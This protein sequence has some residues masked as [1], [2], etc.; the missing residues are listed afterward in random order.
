LFTTPMRLRNK[1]NIAGNLLRDTKPPIAGGHQCQCTA[2]RIPNP[3]RV[4]PSVPPQLLCRAD[5]GRRSGRQAKSIPD[6]DALCHRGMIHQRDG[7]SPGSKVAAA[8]IR[9]C[10][11]DYYQHPPYNAYPWRSV[12]VPK[13][14]ST[15]TSA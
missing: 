13:C 14:K 4:N 10:V 5:N 11:A 15:P 9:P 8:F 2:R 3:G 1:S 7:I 12:W 6:P